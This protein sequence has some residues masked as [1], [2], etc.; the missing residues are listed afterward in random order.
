MSKYG[1][2]AR[3]WEALSRNDKESLL[4]WLV[5]Y[6]K[7]KNIHLG[8]LPFVSLDYLYDVISRMD[9]YG[10]EYWN[11]TRCDSGQSVLSGALVIERLKKL[12][13]QCDRKVE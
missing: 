7:Y 4:T 11:R 5:T 10:I 13:A 8:T 1:S 2:L 12:E 6:E 3:H 9:L